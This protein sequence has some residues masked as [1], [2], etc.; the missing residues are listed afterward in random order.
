MQTNYEKQE[1]EKRTSYRVDAFE[2]KVSKVK[3]LTE[4]GLE[5]TNALD[6]LVRMVKPEL[7]R[8]DWLETKYAQHKNVIKGLMSLNYDL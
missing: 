4:S 5:C 7:E 3:N 6:E 8:I 1:S 2:E